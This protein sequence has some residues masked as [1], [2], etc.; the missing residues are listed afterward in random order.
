MN[1]QTR[2]QIV[3]FTER[4]SRNQRKAKQELRTVRTQHPTR[5][6]RISVLKRRR[7]LNRCR[8]RG[9]AGM[10]RWVGL[11][12]IADTLINVVGS[13]QSITVAKI[14]W[15]ELRQ[16]KREDG[17]AAS[18]QYAPSRFW[19]LLVRNIYFCAAK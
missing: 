18:R 17:N 7:G 4:F 6:G 12:V 3:K 19:T 1:G 2:E 13:W 16:Q 9:D 8:Y 15:C 14:S 5:K 11:G 10:Q